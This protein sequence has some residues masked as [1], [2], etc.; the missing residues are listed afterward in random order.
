M[1][2]LIVTSPSPPPADSTGTTTAPFYWLCPLQVVR[3]L[4][5]NPKFAESFAYKP[6]F[7]SEDEF[8]TSQM[9]QSM[10]W[11]KMQ[12]EIGHDALIAAIISN[13]DGVYTTTRHEHVF[14]YI[15]LANV[16]APE[17]FKPE[18]SVCIG[19]M[20]QFKREDGNYQNDEAYAR[21]NTVVYHAALSAMF[22]DFNDASRT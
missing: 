5:K 4:M 8:K 16:L 2:I 15:R 14:F 10:W 17:G 6:E 7:V 13:S 19:V 11:H 21:A 18:H 1:A 3:L 20:P 22:K 12:E 9:N